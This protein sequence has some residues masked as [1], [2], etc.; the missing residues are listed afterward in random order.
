MASMTVE[1]AGSSDFDELMKMLLDAFKSN[2]PGH[3][4]FPELFPDIYRPDEEHMRWN[5]IIRQ[6]G[7]IVGCVGVLPI[8]INACGRKVE[9]P[10]IGG[11]SCLPECRGQGV[12]E[13]IMDDALKTMVDK[14]YGFSWL[15][16]DRRR[17]QRWGYEVAS[18]QLMYEIGSR[19]PGFKGLS[20]VLSAEMR[21]ADL[22]KDRDILSEQV[23]SNFDIAVNSDEAVRQKYQRLGQKVYISG[24]GKDGGHIAVCTRDGQS[25]L[26]AWAG[27]VDVV[28]G[29]VAEYINEHQCNLKAVLPLYRDKYSPVFDKLMTSWCVTWWGNIAVL[30]IAR[31]LNIFKPHLDSRVRR[32]GSRGKVELN[33]PALKSIPA[34]RVVL[35]A[36]G[37]ELKINASDDS[38]EPGVDIDRHEIVELLFTPKS[39]DYFSGLDESA[40]WITALF[41]LPFY[42][43][44]IGRV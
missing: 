36:D 39:I 33:V 29:M 2:N 21:E 42:L 13:T 23:K 8:A 26:T 44:R 19:A 32:F 24:G 35:E 6:G 16:G 5:H 40:S 1:R 7:K 28:G 41:P 43:P 30:D 34:E 25:E 9:I 38:A 12:M 3:A 37:N 31:T 10:G 15:A 20:G 4:E 14:G 11:V 22:D 27:P 18:N 17:Y